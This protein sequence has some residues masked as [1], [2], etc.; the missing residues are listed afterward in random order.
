MR[1]LLGAAGWK[2]VAVVL[3]QAR[4]AC[5][6][7][8]SNAVTNADKASSTEADFACAELCSCATTA[9]RVAIAN[10][11]ITMCFFQPMRAPRNTYEVYPQVSPDKRGYRTSAF[12]PKIHL[13]GN[14]TNQEL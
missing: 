8:L 7:R 1:L 9:C 4:K 12:G 2:M 11:Q 6:S 5:Q 14:A 13:S 10:T 3:K